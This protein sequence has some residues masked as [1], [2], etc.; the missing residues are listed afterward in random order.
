MRDR[1]K[2]LIYVLLRCFNCQ[3]LKGDA[4]GRKSYLRSAEIEFFCLLLRLILE[5]EEEGESKISICYPK[6]LRASPWTTATE[7][8]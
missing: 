7:L 8:A 2:A 5:G 3:W 1:Q 6:G 4:V